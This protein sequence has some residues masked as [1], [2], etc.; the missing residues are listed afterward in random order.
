MGGRRA[1]LSQAGSVAVGVNVGKGVGVAVG[2]GVAKAE[3]PP[4]SVAETKSRRNK[5]IEDRRMMVVRG[6]VHPAG[7][8]A[9]IIPERFT[10]ASN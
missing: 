4:A 3:H 10:G 5:P 6:K 2:A 8:Q 1:R 9:V 7:W